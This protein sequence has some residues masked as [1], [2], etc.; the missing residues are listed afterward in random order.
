V[1]DQA[2]LEDSEREREQNDRRPT[3]ACAASA[4]ADDNGRA[5][6][7]GAKSNKPMCISAKVIDK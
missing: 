7:K 3:T 5:T 1:V 4:L 2:R 6:I